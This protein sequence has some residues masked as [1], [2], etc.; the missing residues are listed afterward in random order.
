MKLYCLTKEVV[1]EDGQIEKIVT[2]GPTELPVCTE[3]VSNF[4]LAGDEFVKTYGWLPVEIDNDG[5]EIFVSSSFEIL[6]DKVIQHIVNRNKTTAEKW[7]EIRIQRDQLLVESDKL[8]L[9]DRWEAMTAEEKQKISTYR[10]ALRDIPTSFSKP[11]KV[12]FP[13]L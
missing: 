3:N 12:V 11:E 13:T 10:Q 1:L 8:A 4:N 5:K 2:E 6:E 7:D 9:A